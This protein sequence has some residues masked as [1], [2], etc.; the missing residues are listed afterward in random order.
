MI[1]DG[2][3]SFAFKTE[4]VMLAGGFYPDI[5]SSDVH[6]LIFQQSYFTGD[7]ISLADLSIAPAVDFFTQTPEWPIL[8]RPHANLVAW[9]G[10]MQARPSMKATTWERLSEIAQ[11]A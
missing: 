4:R 1:R 5:I 6:A 3:G 10:R 11:A 2:K 7:T 9:L 8:G